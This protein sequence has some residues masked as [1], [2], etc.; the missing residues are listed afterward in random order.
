MSKKINFS[1]TLFDKIAEYILVTH[2]STNNYP[3]Y[4]AIAELFQV[5]MDEARLYSF[6]VINRK[7][8]K[9]YTDEELRNELQYQTSRT[10]RFMD[11]NNKL[12]K[13]RREHDRLPNMLEV[14]NEEMIKIMR[15]YEPVYKPS[16]ANKTNWF[17]DFASPLH[18][19]GGIQIG[20]WHINELIQIMGL[21]HFDI[22]TAS[23]MVRKLTDYAKFKFESLGITKVVVLA[24]GDFVNSDRRYDEKMHMATN[25]TKASFICF[26]LIRAMLLDLANSFEQVLFVGVTGNESRVDEELGWDELMM[27]DNYDYSIYKQLGYHFENHSNI[28]VPE[29]DSYVEYVINVAGSWVLVTH[30]HQRTLSGGDVEK[31]VIQMVGKWAARGYNIDHIMFGHLHYSRAGDHFTRSASLPGA[32]AYSNNA[33]QLITKSAQMVHTFFENKDLFTERVD[34]NHLEGITPYPY[35]KDLEAYHAKSLLKTKP[36]TAIFQVRI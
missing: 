16:D 21:N 14:M 36:G 19:V 35:N 32:N 13:D 15:S 5:S 6:P 7:G 9:L 30:G 31:G 26:E 33:L 27:T 17:K 4:S 3:T 11:T 10:Q 8:F 18:K 1:E 29:Q 20:D 12:R 2:A 25:R 23:K 24:V 22:E 28:H 34:L